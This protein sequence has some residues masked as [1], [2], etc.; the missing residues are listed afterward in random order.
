MI[1]LMGYK[2]LTLAFLV[3]IFFLLSIISF[4][5]FSASD[6]N[7]N[8]NNQKAE[9]D[10]GC[11]SYYGMRVCCYNS[12]ENVQGLVTTGQRI[13]CYDS[14]GKNNFADSGKVYFKTL[15]TTTNNQSTYTVHDTCGAS[16]GAT[17]AYDYYCPAGM[18]LDM[19]ENGGS[20]SEITGNAAVIVNNNTGT[21]DKNSL[22]YKGAASPSSFDPLTI[23]IP[24]PYTIKDC[25]NGCANGICTSKSPAIDL[26]GSF[27]NNAGVVAARV[28]CSANTNLGMKKGSMSVNVA[29]TDSK[30]LL[31]FGDLPQT[32]CGYGDTN[33]CTLSPDGFV[34][35][36]YDSTAKAAFPGTWAITCSGQDIQGNSTQDTVVFGTT[37]SPPCYDSVPPVISDFSFD[38]ISYTKGLLWLSVSSYDPVSGT[39]YMIL[40][41]KLNDNEVLNKGIKCKKDKCDFYTLLQGH[42]TWSATLVAYDISGNM[43]GETTGYLN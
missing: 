23:L 29:A 10:Y 43:K 27:V 17:K 6:V 30:G 16:S 21:P 41:V 20:S 39:D 25:P 8:P 1:W 9:P 31:V 2:W 37:C 22:E 11:Y 40:K 4:K 3:A 42:G 12:T 19:F 32:T 13:C 18:P 5:T 14:D 28:S 15:N 38:A 7:P 24:V 33:Y 36:N 34:I 26:S 35:Y